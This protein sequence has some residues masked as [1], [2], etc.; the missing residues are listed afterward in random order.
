MPK[1]LAYIQAL[2]EKHVPPGEE[3]SQATE[4]VQSLLEEIEV[5]DFK[6]LKYAKDNEIIIRMLEANTADLQDQQQELKELNRILISKQK[7]VNEQNKEL[8]IAKKL[9]DDAVKAKEEFLSLMSHEIRTPL[10]AIIGISYLLAQQLKDTQA[11]KHIDV[12]QH[13]GE[14][15]LLLVTDVLDYHQLKAQK[16]QLNTKPFALAKTVQKTFQLFEAKAAEKQLYYHLSIDP[17]IPTWLMGDAARLSQIITNLLSN[18][19]KFTQKGSVQLKVKLLSK[20][21]SSALI[22]FIVADTGIGIPADKQHTVFNSFEQASTDT[23]QQHGGSGLGLSIVKQLL[24][25]KNAPIQIQSEVGKGTQ[26]IFNLQFE[27][28]N[29][30]DAAATV[31]DAATLKNL[32][33]LMVEDDAFNIQVQ[34]AVLEQWKL[35]VYVAENGITALELCNR[36]QF[37]FILLDINLPDIDGT[38]LAQILRLKTHTKHTPIIAFT[39][40]HSEEV[41]ASIVAAGM[42]DLITK[43]FHPQNLLQIL[44]QYAPPAN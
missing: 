28:A 6:L 31:F 2:L 18:G 43:P 12:L 1:R 4:Y 26:F 42:N 11:Q 44:L 7:E 36:K 15:L 40:H 32:K 16:V 24:T 38:E 35:Q 19:I 29:A 22:Q 23:Y 30:Q 5:A 25:L 39:A 20:T 41:K 17:Q 9:A 21:S 10:N 3:L 34:K 27:I 8:Q 13:A 14:N 37:D 33:V